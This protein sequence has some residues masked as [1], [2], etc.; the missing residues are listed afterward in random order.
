MKSQVRS[1]LLQYFA[2]KLSSMV[3]SLGLLRVSGEIWTRSEI[4]VRMN[5]FGDGVIK[6]TRAD[7]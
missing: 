7:C 1:T 6:C 4:V 2:F 3:C 5:M